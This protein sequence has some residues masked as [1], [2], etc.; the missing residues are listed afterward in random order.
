MTRPGPLPLVLVVDD[1]PFIARVVR[2]VLADHGLARVAVARSADAMWKALAAEKP[3]LILL[4]LLLPDAHGLGLLAALR[5]C[6]EYADIPVVILTSVAT[7]SHPAD[8]MPG[9]AAV[10]RKPLSPRALLKTVQ[11][12]LQNDHTRRSQSE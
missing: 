4:D 7:G 8:S 11:E 12:L 5:E 6:P 3:A 9:A 10:L 1:E 2:L